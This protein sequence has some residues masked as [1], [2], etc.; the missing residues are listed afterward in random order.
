MSNIKVAVCLTTYNHAEYISQAIEIVLSQKTNFDFLLVIGEDGSVDNTIKICREYERK[1]PTKINVIQYE[2]NLGLVKNTI[3]LYK[4]I[5]KRNIEYIAML[6]GD[7]YWIDNNKLQRQIDSL[8]TNPESGLSHTSMQ[9]LVEG[10]VISQKK[11]NLKEENNSHLHLP[12]ANCTVV[13]RTSLISK[14]DMEYIAS[15]NFLSIDYITA[16]IFSYNTKFTYIDEST[17]VW[18]RGHSSVSNPNNLKKD[19]EYVK[20]HVNVWR[21][22]NKLYPEVLF[23]ESWGI[24]YIKMESLKLAYKYNDYKLAK[25]VTTNTPLSNSGESKIEGMRSFFAKNRLLFFI[26]CSIYKLRNMVRTH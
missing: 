23:E 4:F 7:D 17:A 26:Y 2:T 6:D 16:V 11:R 20:H 19:I 24:S 13:F 21:Y 25:D 18:R 3:E 5:K 12:L 9:L 1:Y 14:L 10:K 22:I 8:D 15:Q